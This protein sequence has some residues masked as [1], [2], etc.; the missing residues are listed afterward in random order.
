M[1]NIGEGGSLFLRPS[2]LL[3]IQEKE[4]VLL[5]RMLNTGIQGSGGEAMEATL[6]D[7]LVRRMTVISLYISSKTK[8]R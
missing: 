1:E 5:T 6:V 7:S 2:T 3:R 4:T 8:L